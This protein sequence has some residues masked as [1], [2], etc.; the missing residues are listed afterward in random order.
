MDQ[1]GGE[2]VFLFEEV[3]DKL[4]ANVD[5]FM[6]PVKED[7]GQGALR[8]ITG[9]AKSALSIGL[10]QWCRGTICRGKGVTDLGAGSLGRGDSLGGGRGGRA[11]AFAIYLRGNCA[12]G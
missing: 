10:G 12:K 8:F 6:E 1:L 2:C 7:G 5:G 9:V 4:S 11:W 3:G